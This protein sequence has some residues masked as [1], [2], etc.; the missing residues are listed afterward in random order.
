VSEY[1]K[2]VRRLL[3]DGVVNEEGSVFTARAQ[4][5]NPLP[6]VPVYLAA[7]R[8][9]MIRLAVRVGDGIVVWLCSPRYLREQV[10]PAVREACAEFG[11]DEKD[12]TVLTILPAYVGDRGV[13]MLAGWRRTI[14]AYRLLPYY[15]HVLDAHGTVEPDQLA[16][17]GTPA[18][19]H[20][21]LEEY[22]DIGCLP[23]PSPMPGTDE[24]FT[25][26][27]EEVYPASR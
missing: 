7:L 19:I 20:A 16:L 4:Y 10:M 18:E 1:V 17:L 14:G 26:T 27:I 2:I 24:E 21:R 8:P 3:V 23:V 22:R 13:D 6:P 5:T 11:R 9:Q 15:R 12:F 25:Q